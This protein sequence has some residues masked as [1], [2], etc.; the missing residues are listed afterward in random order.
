MGQGN[1]LVCDLW[2]LHASFVCF[3]GCSAVAG[4]GLMLKWKLWMLMGLW[5][6][7]LD[8]VVVAGSPVTPRQPHGEWACATRAMACKGTPSAGAGS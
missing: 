6:L 1:L 3:D 8:A 2:Q 4:P 7:L 5:G